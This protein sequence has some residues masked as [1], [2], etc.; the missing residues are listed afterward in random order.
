MESSAAVIRTARVRK[1][2]A[3]DSVGGKQTGDP[4]RPRGA[5]ATT[6]HA[7][8]TLKCSCLGLSWIDAAS[9]QSVCNSGT[10]SYQSA[11]LPTR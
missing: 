6:E 7:L 11:M 10:A 3:F 5:D 4:R 2:S 9:K 8:S 1:R